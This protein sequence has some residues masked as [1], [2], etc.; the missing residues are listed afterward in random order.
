MA[1]TWHAEKGKEIHSFLEPP[2]KQASPA[3]NLTLSWWDSQWISD[4]QRCEINLC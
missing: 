2:G 3:D 1:I 4:L